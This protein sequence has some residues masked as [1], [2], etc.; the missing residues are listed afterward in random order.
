MSDVGSTQS[1]ENTAIWMS[2][3]RETKAPAWPAPERGCGR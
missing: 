3:S 1:P 2:G